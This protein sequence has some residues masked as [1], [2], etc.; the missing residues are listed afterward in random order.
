MQ[1]TEDPEALPVETKFA[2]LQVNRSAPHTVPLTVECQYL[3]SGIPQKEL[4]GPPL[5]KLRLS[6][7][8]SLSGEAKAPISLLEVQLARS[9]LSSELVGTLY[10]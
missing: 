5:V 1:R 7:N 9:A 8:G 3:P 4:V 10:P 6:A 2:E